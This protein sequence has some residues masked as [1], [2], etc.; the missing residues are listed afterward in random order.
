M[1][2]LVAEDDLVLQ[3]ILKAQFDLAGY[4]ID[5]V[6]NGE[7]L[8]DILKTTSYEFIFTDLQMPKMDGMK[9]VE[10]IRQTDKEV[11][12][13]AMSASINK[14]DK[15]NLTKIGFNYFLIKPF[16]QEELL[17][18]LKEHL[19]SDNYEYDMQL[20]KE[21]L[22]LPEEFILKQLHKMSSILN[23]DLV[24]MLKYIDEKN[25][26]AL[27]EIAHKLKGRVGTLRIAPMYEI[28]TQIE[29]SAKECIDDDYSTMLKTVYSINKSLKKL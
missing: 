3:G 24:I 11:I 6:S 28:F 10:L 9:A 5:I 29:R 14:K 4:R 25:Y 23:D 13:I 22:N 27:S 18:I 20:T 15:E 26:E 21:A 16:K 17:S 12:I 7:E 19:L 8:L 1:N 2:I